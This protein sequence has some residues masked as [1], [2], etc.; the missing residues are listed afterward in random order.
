VAHGLALAGGVSR[1][2]FWLVLVQLE[3]KAAPFNP[4]SPRFEPRVA[5]LLPHQP[6]ARSCRIERALWIRPDSR[7]PRPWPLAEQ[8]HP[9]K[10]AGR[11][12]LPVLVLPVPVPVHSD[13]QRAGPRQEIGI[14]DMYCIG[15]VRGC[16]TA[17]WVALWPSSPWPL[18]PRRPTANGPRWSLLGFL[19]RLAISVCRA[20]PLATATTSHEGA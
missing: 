3:C 15:A 2:W 19:S 5:P 1:C 9:P 14:L 4:L 20:S 12:P 16:Y 13:C 6:H 11:R 7:P 10:A 18:A 8:A 17:G